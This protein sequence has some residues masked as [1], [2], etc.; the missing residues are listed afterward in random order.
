VIPRYQKILFTVLLLASLG[1]GLKLWQLRDRAHKRLLAGETSA[2]TQAP[3]VAPAEQATLVAANDMD[4][5]LI[6]QLHSLPL[7]TDPEARAR[8]VLGKLLDL[9]AA[10]N[11]THVVPGAAASVAQVFLVP[12]PGAL[13]GTKASDT[14]TGNQLAVVNLTGTFAASH[15]SGLETESLT[16]LSICATL[17]ANLPNVAEVRF[18]VD[19][20][21]RPT[22]AGHADLTRTYLTADSL[23]TSGNSP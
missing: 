11:S 6:P 23:P 5:S 13:P 21:P 16:V 15:P 20:Q 19:G 12:I 9:Y 8:A 3:E 7:P 2:P 18:L 22:L 17:R 4:N 14:G 10:P 1:M